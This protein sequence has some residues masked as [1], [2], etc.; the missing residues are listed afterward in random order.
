MYKKCTL[1]QTKYMK[2]KNSS[3]IL[4]LFFS[5]LLFFGQNLAVILPKLCVFAEN[6][7]ADLCYLA[8]IIDDFGGY[9]RGGVEEML[10]ISVP[11]TCAVIP[12]S[13][14]TKIDADRCVK[15]G[16][17][18]ILHMPMESHVLLP[19]TWYGPVFITNNE[20]DNAA[21]NKLD[22]CLEELPMAKGANIHIGSG[23]SQNKELMKTIIGHLKSK[24]KYFCDSRTILNT[25]C[26]EA[27]QALE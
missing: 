12:F 5:L 4:S 19:E 27:S 10:Q 24:D 9:D 8:I 11:L 18:V 25:K 20:N 7:G 17:E 16:H 3:M 22:K 15:A 21:K 6:N 13:D 14:N 23:V 26:E 2:N 1:F